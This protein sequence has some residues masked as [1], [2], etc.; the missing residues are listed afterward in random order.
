MAAKKKPEPKQSM[1]FGGSLE[2][3]NDNLKK[4][5]PKKLFGELPIKK[6]W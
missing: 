4:Q 5:K 2:Q 3:I 6:N 1:Q